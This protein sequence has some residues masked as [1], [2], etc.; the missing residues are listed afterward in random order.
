M[1]QD[2]RERQ[3]QRELFA[4]YLKLR[5]QQPHFANARSVRNAVTAVLTMIFTYRLSPL[6]VSDVWKRERRGAM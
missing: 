2:N 6:L 3:H 4:E 5:A 1:S